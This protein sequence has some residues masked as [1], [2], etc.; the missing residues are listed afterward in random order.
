MEKTCGAH[1]TR[2]HS[3]NTKEEE[4]QES[5]K[6]RNFSDGPRCSHMAERSEQGRG[7]YTMSETIAKQSKIRMS[8]RRSV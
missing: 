8:A 7:V 5:E 4:G 2:R 1:R 6:Q 3:S